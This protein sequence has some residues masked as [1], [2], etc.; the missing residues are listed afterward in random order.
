M[1]N[2]NY[3]KMQSYI[4]KFH[5]EKFHIEFTTL[6]LYWYLIKVKIYL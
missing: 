5:K 1:R 2:E 3:D 6:R 4:V